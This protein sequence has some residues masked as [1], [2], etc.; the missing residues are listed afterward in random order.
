MAT[1]QMQSSG[2]AAT[3]CLHAVCHGA[4][5]DRVLFH[6]PKKA[7]VASGSRTNMEDGLADG[8]RKRK[9]EGKKKRS[10]QT[11][12]QQKERAREK[13]LLGETSVDGSKMP[14]KKFFRSRAHCNP[15]SYNNSFDYPL[16]PSEM[17]WST[18]FP[19]MP[20]SDGFKQVDFIDVGCGFGGLTISLAKEFP[21]RVSLGLEIRPKVSEYVRRRITALQLE[22]AE[23][24]G[25]SNA[26]VLT[27][28][29]MKYLPNYFQK[30][31]LSK[32]FICFAD[33]HFKKKNHR[34]RIISE[35]LLP[36]YSYLLK[37]GGILYTVTDVEQ[38][39]IWQRDRCDADPAFQ[40]LSEEELAQDPCVHLMQYA[41]EES[42]KVD[43]EGKFGRTKYV[44][45]YR[46]KPDKDIV[47]SPWGNLE[48]DD[49]S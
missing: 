45:V 15:L 20:T 26:G 2:R 31:Q 14:Q 4:R 30:G 18:V 37:P 11:F 48:K 5:E 17:D 9:R 3:T 27:T 34:R 16:K 28:N 46:R 24:N 23:Q 38:L 41:T 49:D 13:A 44:A 1:E 33:P 43:R 47:P 25:Y 12:K 8:S 7:V 32:I 36:V 42:K 19:K 29:A 39:Y 21:D 40:K 22:H 10:R 6:R 35:A